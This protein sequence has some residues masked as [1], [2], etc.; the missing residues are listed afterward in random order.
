MRRGYAQNWRELSWTFAR[1]LELLKIATEKEDSGLDGY[2]DSILEGIVSLV[3]GR[4]NS[5]VSRIQSLTSPV[6]FGTL[7]ESI[8]GSLPT[9]S[10]SRT[11]VVYLFENKSTD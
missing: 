5:D 10:A 2:I 9:D 6:F 3:G 4:G 11:D 7:A 1:I 8:G